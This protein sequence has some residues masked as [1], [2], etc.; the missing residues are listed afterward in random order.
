MDEFQ[1]TVLTIHHCYMHTMM[2]T[3]A[4]KIIENHLGD[5]MIKYTVSTQVPSGQPNADSPPD[6]QSS[7]A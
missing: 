3:P 7:F 5:A 4:T 2:N 6:V 1:D